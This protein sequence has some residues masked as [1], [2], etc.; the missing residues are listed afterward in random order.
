MPG[1]LEFIFQ[2]NLVK[3]KEFSEKLEEFS[4]KN[5]KRTPRIHFRIHLFLNLLKLK[6]FSEKIK[7][8][9]KNLRILKKT[10]IFLWEKE[11]P[12]SWQERPPPQPPSLSNSVNF[13]MPLHCQISD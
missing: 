2:K 9:L 10:L 8:F 11:P 12:P 6:E 3:L 7:E 1:H 5:L 13:L 4:K